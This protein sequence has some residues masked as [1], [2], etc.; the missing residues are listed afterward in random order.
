MNLTEAEKQYL[1]MG[2]KGRFT[3]LGRGV[4]ICE[5]LAARKLMVQVSRGS[6]PGFEITEDGSAA[7]ADA[8]K[9]VA[10]S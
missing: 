3:P 10:A 6:R 4:A 2:A 8:E 5:Y 1:R 7:L 9:T